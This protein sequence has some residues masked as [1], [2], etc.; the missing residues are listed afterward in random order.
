MIF[1]INFTCR[2]NCELYF[3]LRK[4][5]IKTSNLWN[6]DPLSFWSDFQHEGSCLP[7]WIHTPTFLTYRITIHWL[8]YCLFRLSNYYS[9]EWSHQTIVCIHIINIYFYNLPIV[10]TWDTI[11]YVYVCKWDEDCL[12]LS[13]HW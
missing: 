6:F 13:F 3:L 12:Y 1:L 2:S 7:F 8:I 11:T 9:E 4:S 5:S 10:P